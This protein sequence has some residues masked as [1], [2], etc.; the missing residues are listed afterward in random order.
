MALLN[1]I[2][3][4]LSHPLNQGRPVA[5]LAR[6]VKWQ[7]GSR[8]LGMPVLIP[9]AGNGVLIAQRGMRGA[10]GNLYCGLHEYPGMAFVAHALQRGDLFVDVG[11]NI[12]SYSILAA[13]AGGARVICLEPVPETYQSLRR[14][15]GVNLLSDTI[16]TRNVVAADQSGTCRVTTGTDTTNHVATDDDSSQDTVEVEAATLDEVVPA[17]EACIIKID[18]EGFEHAALSGAKRLLNETNLLAIIV[19]INGSTRRY[20][21]EGSAVE[22]FIRQAGFEPVSY[23][24][25]QRRLTKL[26]K[27]KPNQERMTGN[28]IFVRDFDAVQRRLENADPIQVFG[29][30]V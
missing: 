17:D 26:K 29:R 8:L 18:V 20:G 24:P 25:D 15:V 16:D 1:T 19:E 27:Q 28:T 30:A 14:N 5:T 9:M 21:T 7:L 11:A 2:R 23:K 3:F 12:G 10:T 22:Q 13:T 6:F 4:I